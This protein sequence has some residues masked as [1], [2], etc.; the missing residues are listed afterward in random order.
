MPLT[1][2]LHSTI[3]M[4]SCQE[5]WMG[6]RDMALF[7]QLKEISNT[8]DEAPKKSSSSCRNLSAPKHKC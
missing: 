2:C 8:K 3:V 5:K 1:V 7:S 6:Y 4:H